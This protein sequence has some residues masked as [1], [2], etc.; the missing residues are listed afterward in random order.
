[1]SDTFSVGL[2]QCRAGRG[3][4]EARREAAEGVREAARLGAQVICL[5]ELFCGPYFCSTEEAA[6]C[7]LAEAVDGPAVSG[8]SAL[9]AQLGVSIVVPFFEK[10]AHPAMNAASA[11]PGSEAP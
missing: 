3:Y 8:M 4:D 1:M 10:R 7:A 9:A 6:N 5:Q 2:V 11:L